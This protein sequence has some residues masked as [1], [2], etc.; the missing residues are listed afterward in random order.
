MGWDVENQETRC[1]FNA[2]C[3]IILTGEVIGYKFSQAKVGFPYLEMSKTH[4][5]KS[6]IW[7]LAS[8]KFEVAILW[9]SKANVSPKLTKT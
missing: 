4:W 8:K 9:H 1:L 5:F 6:R 3:D 2:I 7:Q